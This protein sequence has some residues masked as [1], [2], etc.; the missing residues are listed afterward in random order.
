MKGHSEVCGFVAQHNATDV[1]KVLRESALGMLTAG[2]NEEAL[3]G[4]MLTHDAALDF[5]EALMNPGVHC[6]WQMIR[7][8]AGDQ[9]ADVSVADSV[10]HGGDQVIVWIC[11]SYRQ[12]TQEM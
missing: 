10:P 12:K 11:I 6:T 8:G 3:H 1:T 7:R 4:K 2:R 9:L 5:G